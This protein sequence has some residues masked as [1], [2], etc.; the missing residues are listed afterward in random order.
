M[1]TSIG[2]MVARL[3]LDN[4]GLRRDV[5]TA[6]NTLAK[7]KRTA[8]AAFAGWAS[9]QG[10]RRFWGT[11]LNSVE[12]YNMAVI[13]AAALMTGMMKQQP[14]TTLAMQ[15]KQAKD[16]AS[17]LV[18]KLEE[19]DAKTIL[20]AQDLQLINREL[21]K[22]G[23]I[24][25]VNNAKQVQSFT[26]IAN[27]VAVISAGSPNKQIQLMQE[28][29]ALLQGQVNVHSQLALMLDAQTGDLKKQVKLHKQQGDLI[30]W[31]GNELRGFAAAGKDLEFTWEAI[32]STLQ[33]IYR[34]T[35]RGG[36]TVAFNDILGILRDISIWAKGHQ[37][38]LETGLVR[39]WESAKGWIIGA[40]NAMDQLSGST[41]N[42]KELVSTIVDGLSF[43]STVIVP[44]LGTALGGLFRPVVA[45][46]DYLVAQISRAELILKRL[47][48]A[49]A[50]Y[51][52]GNQPSTRSRFK[53]GPNGEAIPMGEET[54]YGGQTRAEMIADLNAQ[55]ATVNKKA[56]E[57]WNRWKT[58]ATTDIATLPAKVQEAMFKGADK[59]L[60]AQKSAAKTA[61]T[62][63]VL[64]DLNAPSGVSESE[65][66]KW[67]KKIKE[68]DAQLFKDRLDIAYRFW[69][70]NRSWMEG[71]AD[72]FR[73][74]ANSIKSWA[75]E[76]ASA[77]N[78][79]FQTMEDSLVNFIT[80]GKAEFSS[81]VSSIVA[82]L[83]RIVVR[84]Q[85]TG[86]IA[87]A[88]SKMFTTSAKGNVFSSKSGIKAHENEIVSSPTFFQFARGAN[89]GVAGEAGAE[90]ILPLTR[91]SSG[92]LGVEAI[93]SNQ[94][95]EVNIHNYAGVGVET[96]FS[97]NQLDI[98]L[99]TV[100]RDMETGGRTSA[101]V[102]ASV[103][104]G[105]KHNY[106]F[107]KTIMGT[108]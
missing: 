94:G 17:E 4:S 99:T 19:V 87:T 32:G 106:G 50:P 28:T 64:P 51:P 3:R 13:Q 61:A 83:A 26:N 74:Y 86:P 97:D 46:I 41:G 89:I 36:L 14:G 81:M 90:A 27:A 88:L 30:E 65:Q 70:Q 42:L 72:G 75:T 45:M 73:D 7:L 66:K 39:T 79:A 10:I 59:Y 92:N 15:Y 60:A 101:G 12:S 107:R 104:R 84:Q 103:Q 58:A 6:E 78:R 47:S 96:E 25:D 93:T 49:Y 9:V 100:A 55:Y 35:V 56:E 40:K 18:L 95:M 69:E 38:D 24:L 98:I 20:N 63:A 43:F 2:D 16:Y 54:T 67:N 62:G 108:T 77:T 48:A 11:L 91:T 31:L 76:M 23:Q 71:A 57:A 1:S 29:R 8:I 5:S 21:M 22:Q 53:I 34:R 80:T 44:G 82:D 85:I 102:Q 68:L 105:L 52:G 37:T 33:T